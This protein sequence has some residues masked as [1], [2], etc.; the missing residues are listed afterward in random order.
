MHQ[1]CELSSEF[2]SQVDAIVVLELTMNSIITTTA[3][4]PPDDVCFTV[5]T[6]F[7]LHFSPAVP[8]STPGFV[9]SVQAGRPLETKSDLQPP[10]RIHSS[11]QHQ[12]N[13]LAPTAGCRRC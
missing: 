9:A 1:C 5:T 8:D 11:E 12:S 3:S 2:C 4:C 7:P 10:R 13:L 6:S